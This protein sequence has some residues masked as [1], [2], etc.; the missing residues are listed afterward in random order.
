M[1]A[2]RGRQSI[3][4]TRLSRRLIAAGMLARHRTS[5]MAAATDEGPALLRL[6]NHKPVFFIS[7][8][9][10]DRARQL[11]KDVSS[12][13]AV[14]PLELETFSSSPAAGVYCDTI[15]AG[16]RASDVLRD[17]GIDVF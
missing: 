14:K 16:Y 12:R 4:T 15:Q 1:V 10:A 8:D 5:A 13:I 17:A 7:G 3:L 6:R 2:R 11:L 9:S